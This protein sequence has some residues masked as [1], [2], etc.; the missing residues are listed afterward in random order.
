MAASNCWR[1]I[2][3][4]KQ[5]ADLLSRQVNALSYINFK[6]TVADKRL[7]N[8]Y[9]TWWSDHHRM[10]ED[11]AAA[12]PPRIDSPDAR[13]GKDVVYKPE[14]MSDGQIMYLERH[15]VAF[16]MSLCKRLFDAG[17]RQFATDEAREWANALDV[18]LHEAPIGDVQ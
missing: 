11:A 12:K 18:L 4:R 5:V 13:G 16:L 14:E 10:Q 8:M 6:A 7:H 2:V 17:D 1:V 3:T 9:L 15:Q